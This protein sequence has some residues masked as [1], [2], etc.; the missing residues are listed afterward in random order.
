MDSTCLEDTLIYLGVNR[1]F[2]VRISLRTVPCNS[3][4]RP[5]GN[6]HYFPAAGVTPR[7]QNIPERSTIITMI[8]TMMMMIMMMMRIVMIIISLDLVNRYSKISFNE[9]FSHK[10]KK[11]KS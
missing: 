8:M 9:V 4:V 6:R 2:H 5:C 3:R 7:G 1:I 11:V 10:Y